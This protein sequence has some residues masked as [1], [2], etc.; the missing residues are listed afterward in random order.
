MK[1]RKIKLLPLYLFFGL[2]LLT[3]G[4]ANAQPNLRVFQWQ[5]P[6]TATVNTAYQYRVRVRNMGNQ[7]ALGVKLTIDLPLTNTSPTQHI[8]GKVTGLQT[9]C[10]IVNKKIVCDLLTLN[11]NN[12]QIISFNYEYPVTT[13]P[14][15][16]M[17]T[18]T[19]TSTNE[20]NPNNNFLGLNPSVAYFSNQLTSANVLVSL[21]TG[22]NLTS[23]YE[24]EL[25]P[26][27]IQSFTMTLD[28]GGT[29]S[30]LPEPGY[31]GNW[32]QNSGANTLHFNI[33]DGA[34]G[35]EF[36]GF[37]SSGT[38]FEGITTF[39]P[40]SNYMSAYKVCVQ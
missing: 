6:A 31:F 20:V 24:C 19:T 17:A 7:P 1:E 37:G 12:T 16:L 9:G 3:A 5:G 15:Q 23:F 29:I 14:L 10:A 39:T 25:Y 8:L 38:C 28:Q 33:S 11:P 18:A 22:T 34:S 27:S 26:S 36:N 30:N 2:V 13:K 32:D 35:A 4:V 40:A 21:C